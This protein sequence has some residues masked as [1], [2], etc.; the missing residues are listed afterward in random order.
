[1]RALEAQVSEATAQIDHLQHKNT[2]LSKSTAF[3][4]VQLES[5][6]NSGE[7]GEGEVLRLR[8]QVREQEH[9]RADREQELEVSRGDMERQMADLSTKE[10][11]L[12]AER[13]EARE[14]RDQL[15]LQLDSLHQQVSELTT[16]L[17]TAELAVGVA[18]ASGGPSDLMQTAKLLAKRDLELR[19]AV[20]KINISEEATE[21][22]FTCMQCVRLYE[23][24]VTC[25]PCGHSYC[26]RCVE[27]KGYCTQCGPK[28]KVSYYPNELLED[29]TAKYQF[30]KQALAGI[31]YMLEPGTM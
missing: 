28:V 10:N 12:A 13:E 24:A 8:S 1:V 2:A 17:T 30:R 16:K 14:A 19:A 25:I 31:K 22:S 18:Q 11:T 21:A 26:K 20:A 15:A 3:M 23:Q 7:S 4:E 27:E 9:A 29:L 6:G 5:E